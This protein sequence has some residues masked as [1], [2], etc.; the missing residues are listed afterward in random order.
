MATYVC[1]GGQVR[2][3]K[4]HLGGGYVNVGLHDLC[5]AMLIAL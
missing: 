4:G 2:D 3:G 5:G 1:C